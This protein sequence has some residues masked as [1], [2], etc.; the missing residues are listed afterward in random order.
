LKQGRIKQLIKYSAKTLKEIYDS[1]IDFIFPSAY[2][3]DISLT[4]RAANLV[5]TIETPLTPE[6]LDFSNELG[7]IP[8][9][10]FCGRQRSVL[11]TNHAGSLKGADQ[12]LR[13]KAGN[14]WDLAF[15]LIALFRAEGIPARYVVGTIKMPIDQAME[16]LGVVDDMAATL[17][18][19]N[20]RPTSLIVTGGKI[21]AVETRHVWVQAFIPFN[22]SRGQSPDTATDGWTW[23]P[24]ISH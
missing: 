11:N 13:E 10:I 9:D 24:V 19:S 20:G 2:A 4:E 22:A 23:T 15:L 21:S 18:I 7:D 14:E 8:I 6:I 5:E 17:L 12:T 1:T 3:A 16:W